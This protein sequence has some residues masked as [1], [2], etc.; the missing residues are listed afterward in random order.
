MANKHLWHRLDLTQLLSRASKQRVV[1]AQRRDVTMLMTSLHR[2]SQS[3]QLSWVELRGRC[4]PAI[5]VQVYCRLAIDVLLKNRLFWR[6]RMTQTARRCR[7]WR[8]RRRTTPMTPAYTTR[9]HVTRPMDQWQGRTTW[10]TTVNFKISTR[11]RMSARVIITSLRSRNERLPCGLSIIARGRR[12]YRT[13]WLAATNKPMD[14]AWPSWR[15]HT[16]HAT[17]S[18][19]VSASSSNLVSLVISSL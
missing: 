16:M 4:E 10:M 11:T 7:L 2:R 6:I 14:R 9:R 13:S 12:A 17:T 8:W 19:T 3:R 1:C 15:H 18:G 5:T